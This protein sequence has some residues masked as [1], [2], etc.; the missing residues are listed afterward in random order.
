MEQTS[1]KQDADHHR[2]SFRPGHKPPRGLHAERDFRGNPIWTYREGQGP[3][4]RIR[5]V[6][7]TQAFEE[8]Y[9]AARHAYGRQDGPAEA[10]P[11]KLGRADPASLQWLIDRYLAWLEPKTG[12]GFS[13]STK[14][15]HRNTLARIGL[16]L[17]SC[18]YKLVDTKHIRDLRKAAEEKGTKA[19]ANRAIFVMRALY[20]WAI[21]EAELLPEGSNPATGVETIKVTSVSRH[22]WSD[23]ECDKFEAAYKPGTLPC[24]AYDLYCFTGQRTSDVVKMGW[25]HLDLDEGLM[26][27]VQQKTGKEVHPPIMP[28]LLAS[29][30]AAREAGILGKETFLGSARYDG[31][32]FSADGF[33]N[34]MRA[35]CDAIGIPECTPHGLRH[36]ATMR[37]VAAG[38]D[39]GFLCEVFGY[40]PVMAQRYIDGF[41]GREAVKRG[42]HFLQRKPV[43]LRVVKAA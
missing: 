11:K 30:E 2:Q 14:K 19:M 5:E 26:T 23:V 31:R 21:K 15:E 7:G 28:E 22:K 35:A 41:N 36:K 6:F 20:D 38:A 27:I 10:L 32:A 34:L 12:K 16:K 3:R 13:H 33:G 43:K 18:P 29:I 4:I 1:R 24:L 42:A 9:Y 17:G 37:C 40:T 39:L 25:R 8:A